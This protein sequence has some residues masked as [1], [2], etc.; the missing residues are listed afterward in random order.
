MSPWAQ[1]RKAQPQR[2]GVP[3][4]PHVSARGQSP[5]PQQARQVPP[6]QWPPAQSP[7]PAQTLPS[8]QGGQ[9]PPQSTSVSSPFLRPSAQEAGRQRPLRHAPLGQSAPVQHWRQTLPH[10][11]RP[12]LQA[13]R[14]P[15]HL[16]PEQHRWPGR[17]F[18]PA[19]TQAENPRQR[20]EPLAVHRPVLHRPPA[21]A[22]APPDCP[23][24]WRNADRDRA[25]PLA[26]APWWPSA[27]AG[28]P[29]GLPVSAEIR[30]P[31]RCANYGGRRHPPRRASPVE[32]RS[33]ATTPAAIAARFGSAASLRR[34]ARRHYPRRPGASPAAAIRASRASTGRWS[35]PASSP[36]QAA[37]ARKCGVCQT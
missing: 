11:F 36:T 21:G 12:G 4:P 1:P 22:L 10:R 5:S 13:Q 17:H 30:P 35:E 24:N 16:A 31:P 18:L 3:P 26:M 23:P 19:A 37:R 32:P 6:Q 15:V 29:C 27:G 14:L 34:S 2:S 8:A 9:E 33:A 28:T 7:L 20:V 25:W